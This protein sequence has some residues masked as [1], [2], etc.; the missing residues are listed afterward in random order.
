MAAAYDT[1]SGEKIMNAKELIDLSVT[2]TDRIK[3][4]F[5]NQI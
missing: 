2:K 1:C 4:N 5:R 3:K